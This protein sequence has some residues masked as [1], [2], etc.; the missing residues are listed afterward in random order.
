MYINDSLTSKNASNQII[1]RKILINSR[2]AWIKI[3]F[4]SYWWIAKHVGFCL[5]TPTDVREGK[6]GIQSS[7][8]P[9]KIDLVSPLNFWQRLTWINTLR[10]NETLQLQTVLST[11]DIHMYVVPS[12]FSIIAY[13]FNVT[14]VGNVQVTWCIIS[15]LLHHLKATAFLSRFRHW[16]KSKIKITRRCE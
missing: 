15:Y 10:L 3:F 9:L 8:T 1:I 6:V 2:K 14:F 16:W 4:L 11:S 5:Y 7:C 13:I 12:I